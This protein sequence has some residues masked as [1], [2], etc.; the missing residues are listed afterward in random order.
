MRSVGPDLVKAI[1]RDVVRIALLV[2]L[3][4]DS[5]TQYYTT[6]DHD[7]AW[8]GNTYLGVGGLGSVTGLSDTNQIQA[9]QVQLTMNGLPSG[10]WIN[11]ALTEPV[12][13]RAATISAALYDDTWTILDSPVVIF[14]GT[15]D[16]I[17]VVIGRQCSVSLTV[18]NALTAW[19]TP[20]NATFSDNVQ[21]QTYPGDK[22]F[23]FLPQ[24]IDAQ[25]VWGT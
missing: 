6:A 20:D 23:E 9:L 22:F 25:I 21:Q 3:D 7:I 8:S 19:E 14:G 13:G 15:M 24:L 4:F 12:Q 10:P 17:D 5:G 1:E 18:Q 16:L 2:E 11:T